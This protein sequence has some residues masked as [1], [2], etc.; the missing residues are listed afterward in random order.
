MGELSPPTETLH[1]EVHNISKAFRT[2]RGP[3]VALDGVRMHVETNEFV[4]VVGASGSGKSTLLKI[5]AGLLPPS[6]GDVFVDGH[7]VIGPGPDRG[8]VFQNY[9]LYPWLTVA[10]NV[11]YGLALRGVPKA[12]RRERVAHYIQV[13]GLER[14][15]HALPHQLSGGMKQRVAIAR[16]LANEPALLL[17]DEPLGALDAQTRLLMQ[18]F[19]LRLWRETHTTMLLVTHDVAEAAFLGQRVYVLSSNP[20]Q[21]KTELVVPL[22][23]ERDFTVKRTS[24]FHEIERLLVELLREESLKQEPGVDR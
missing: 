3:F 17:M 23:A 16:A 24:A 19:L 7:P 18:E 11:E 10:R 5:I 22:P 8:M 4:C 21:V 6:S 13:V 14:F 12:A 2:R 9:T 15:A 1:L 20:G